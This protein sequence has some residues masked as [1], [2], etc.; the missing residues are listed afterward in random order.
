MICN[1]TWMEMGPGFVGEA[2]RR[3]ETNKMGQLVKAFLATG[4]QSLTHP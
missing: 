3:T 1:Y 2:S 4:H